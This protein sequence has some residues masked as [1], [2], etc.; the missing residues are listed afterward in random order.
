MDTKICSK[1]KRELPLTSFHKNGFDSKGNQKYRGYCKDCANTLEKERYK[2]KK[3]FINEQKHFCEK[4][5]ETRPYVLEFHHKNKEEKDFT[6][7]KC[8]KGDLN[9]IQKEI[10][11]CAVLCSNCHKEFHFLEKEQDLTLEEYLRL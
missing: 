6:V 7:G 9:L 3:T 10:N 1:C 11:K 8:K 5:G 4:C 2:K